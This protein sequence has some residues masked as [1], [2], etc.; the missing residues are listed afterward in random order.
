MSQTDNFRG[1]RAK[2]HRRGAQIY[3]KKKKKK[4]K[5]KRK[6]YHATFEQ[7]EKD[8]VKRKWKEKMQNCK[9]IYIFFDF[10]ENYYVSKNIS[11]NNLNMIKKN[12]ILFKKIKLLFDPAIRPLIQLLLIVKGW[13]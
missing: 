12:Q 6:S 9:N 11:K 7:K 8:R 3:Q 4:T 13:R 5:K 10:I 2:L 1:E